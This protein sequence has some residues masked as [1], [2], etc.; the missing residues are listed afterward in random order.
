MN[1]DTGFGISFVDTMDILPYTQSKQRRVA[2]KY[3]K[4]LVKNDI[5][6]V[7]YKATLLREPPKFLVGS[8][9][10]ATG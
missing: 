6:A 7:T 2:E 9:T 3:L 10:A 8:A 5:A 4:R 1:F